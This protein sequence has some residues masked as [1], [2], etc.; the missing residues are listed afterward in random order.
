MYSIRYGNGFCLRYDSDSI[1]EVMAFRDI[2]NV[3][4]YIISKNEKWEEK[5]IMSV[6]L[7]NE[8][9]KS[10]NPEKHCREGKN[11]GY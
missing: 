11:Y 8:H 5:L 3:T 4:S 7:K 6:S 2:N 1:E 9:E 10:T